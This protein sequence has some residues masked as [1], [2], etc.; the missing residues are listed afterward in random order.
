[1]IRRPPRST[2]LYSSAASDVYKRQSHPSKQGPAEDIS[3]ASQGG[4]AAEIEE[5]YPP[6]TQAAGI[7]DLGC[8]DAQI[9]GSYH[10]IFFYRGSTRLQQPAPGRHRPA[11]VLAQNPT[12]LPKSVLPPTRECQI[13]DL[14]TLANPS[15]PNAPRS[16]Q[17]PSQVTTQVTKGLQTATQICNS[18]QPTV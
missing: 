15:S 16:L 10:L 1:M 12:N 8:Q 13:A 11:N 5:S 9:K 14:G 18:R 6:G 17:G 7:Q 2:P 3:P 4:L